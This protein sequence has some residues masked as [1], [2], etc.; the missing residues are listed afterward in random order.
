MIDNY[1]K[2]KNLKI[3]LSFCPERISQGYGIKE[4]KQIPQIISGNNLKAI[5]ISKKVF[6]KFI[7]KFIVINF[8]EAEVSKLF[9][10]AWRYIKFL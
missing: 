5:L 9:S 1:L 3:N 8:E 4:L 2:K 7:K 6:S 10:N